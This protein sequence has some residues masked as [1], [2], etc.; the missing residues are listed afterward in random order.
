[1]SE[2][3]Q[4]SRARLASEWEARATPG[5]RAPCPR[6]EDLGERGAPPEGPHV[7]DPRCHACSAL[8]DSRA[9]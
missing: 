8:L 1:M 4:P 3:D 2:P 9:A 6:E 5:E 7:Q